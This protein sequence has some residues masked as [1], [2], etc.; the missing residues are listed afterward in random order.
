METKTLNSEFTK[1]TLKGLTSPKKF[2]NSKYFYDEKGSR[3]FQQ[4]MRMPEYY[5]TDCELD[6]FSGQSNQ[7]AELI[8]SHNSFFNLIELGPGDGLK[9]KILL[10]TLISLRADFQY[11]PMDISSVAL[12]DLVNMLRHEIPEL[13]TKEKVGDYFQIL[14]NLHLDNGARKV[15]LFLGSNIGNFL[16]DQLDDFLKKL[17]AITSEGDMVLIG[18]DLKKSPDVLRKAY[19][20][21]H[22]YTRD[23]NL[24]HLVRINRELNANFIIEFFSHHI[25]YN[26]ASGAMESYLVSKCEQSVHVEAFKRVISFKPWESIFMEL[27]QKFTPDEI[28]NLA[29]KHGFQLMRNFSDSRNYFTDSLWVKK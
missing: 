18:F 15:I 26:P 13:S 9:S 29:E 5:L 11:I 4:I 17:A 1:D 12:H 27:S 24:N 25:S 16:P 7:M 14:Q 21:P 10:K 2:L 19:D 23:F 6:I 3:I 20:D 8:I 28:T 22:G